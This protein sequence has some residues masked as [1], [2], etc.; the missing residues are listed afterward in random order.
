MLIL[1]KYREFGQ[2]VLERGAFVQM[3]IERRTALWH[4]DELQLYAMRNW[5]Q[6]LEVKAGGWFVPW[7]SKTSLV[8]NLQVIPHDRWFSPY[9]LIRKYPHP[10][11]Y[12]IGTMHVLGDFCANTACADYIQEFSRKGDYEG[13]GELTLDMMLFAMIRH[14]LGER[15]RSGARSVNYPAN[16]LVNSILKFGQV[17][18][19]EETEG[20]GFLVLILGIDKKERSPQ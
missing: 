5:P 11:S 18:D 3:K 6:L 15:I 9:L 4:V 16:K 8:A 20:P 1:S 10:S 14:S 2:L 19:P 7:K 13:D 17:N 12:D